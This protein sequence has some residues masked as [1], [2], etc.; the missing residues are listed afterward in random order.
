MTTER[1]CDS[2]GQ[3]EGTRGELTLCLSCRWEMC[4][5]CK[6]PDSNHCDKCRDA[7]KKRRRAT[8]L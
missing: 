7:V 2:C 1:Y 6:E 8:A 5:R 3:R 4:S